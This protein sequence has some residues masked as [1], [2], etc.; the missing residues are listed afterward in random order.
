MAIGVAYGGAEIPLGPDK[1]APDRFLVFKAGANFAKWGNQPREVFYC[2][3]QSALQIIAAHVLRGHDMV[4]DFEHQTQPE[5]QR[6]DGKAPAAGWITGFEWVD[7]A[8]LYATAKWTDEAKTLL[9]S[10]QYRYFSPVWFFDNNT[11]RVTE[12][13]SVALT[14]TPAMLD[15]KPLAA[16]SA[17]NMKGKIMDQ[18]LL[19]LGLNAADY[20]SESA[21]AAAIEAIKTLKTQPSEDV[22]ADKT[23]AAIARDCG[24]A[25]VKTAK[26]LTAQVCAT[27][28]AAKT[29]TDISGH[30]QFKAMASQVATLTNQQKARDAEDFIRA[31]RDAGKITVENEELWRMSYASDAAKA[32]ECL[33]KSK[34]SVSMGTL[35]PK[36]APAGTSTRAGAIKAAC[37]EYPALL[38]M[39]SSVTKASYVGTEL[40]AAGEDPTLTED[41]KKM[42]G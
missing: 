18:I 22:V 35:T 32:T 25:D 34:P 41:E 38:K 26:A 39:G 24:W 7:D 23:A 4:I 40:S 19:A 33:D 30:P 28:A 42:I 3:R 16:K 21:V 9:E 10:A 12:L 36:P 1:K 11:M 5:H 15:L 13:K 27:Q 20:D 29:P 6:L 14:N 31:G 37:D 17:K 8:G 2:D